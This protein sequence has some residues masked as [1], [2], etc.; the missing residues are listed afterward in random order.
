MDESNRIHQEDNVIHDSYKAV[1]A[2]RTTKKKY[3]THFI[4]GK[5]SRET[6][7]GVDMLE[8]LAALP[9]PPHVVDVN[10]NSALKQQ[11]V[12]CSSQKKKSKG[13]FPA[14]PSDISL[15]I[16]GSDVCLFEEIDDD[17]KLNDMITLYGNFAVSNTSQDE[18]GR[19]EVIDISTQ[20]KHI[21]L[22][23]LLRRIH[24]RALPVD[25]AT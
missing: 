17:V 14:M 19:G 23:P 11:S 13:N 9:C 7:W 16:E 24:E 25:S 5:I 12:E 4:S 3:T 18:K 20:C 2:N 8:M 21:V 6:Y 22:P 1:I 10:V 15:E